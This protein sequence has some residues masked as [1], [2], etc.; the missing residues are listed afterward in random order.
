MGTHPI[1]E[2]DFDCLTDAKME[3]REAARRI[4]R[5]WLAYRDRQIFRILASVLSVTNEGQDGALLARLSPNEADLFERQQNK[6]VVDLI[7]IGTG[8]DYARFC[9]YQ[10]KSD[11]RIGG[12]DNHWRTV[13]LEALPRAAPLRDLFELIDTASIS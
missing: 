8:E 4:S 3:P 5:A 12:K 9:N 2:S 10:E 7:D 11:A 13:D 1:F 6:H